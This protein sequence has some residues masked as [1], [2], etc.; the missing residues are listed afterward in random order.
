MYGSAAQTLPL[1]QRTIARKSDFEEYD[2]ENPAIWQ[3][4]E[5]AALELIR[6]GIEHYGAKAILE[7]IRRSIIILQ[8]P[9][10][11]SSSISIQNTGTSLS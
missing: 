4:F 5:A 11:E 6:C 10:Q 9:T 7:Y 2:G 8:R 1:F 3:E